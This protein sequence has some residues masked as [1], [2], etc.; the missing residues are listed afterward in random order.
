MGK[1]G[2]DAS[3]FI[4]STLTVKDH[5]AL[6]EALFQYERGYG[7]DLFSCHILVENFLQVRMDAGFHYYCFP[8]AWVKR[9]IEGDYFSIDPISAQS[10]V[11][12]E[13]FDWYD[14]G[15]L[16]KLTPAQEAYL[17]DM[18]D[19]GLVDGLAVP[20]VAAHGTIAYF[21]VG[22]SLEPMPRTDTETLEI[23]YACNHIHNL[24]SE[25]RAALTTKPQPLSPRERE[26][27]SWMAK[28]KSNAVI[29]TTLGISENAVDTLVRRCFQKLDVGDRISAAIKGLG[30]GLVTL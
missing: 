12:S 7:A 10:M 22:S 9:Y 3:S 5:R 15:R 6:F 21:G 17:Q 11:E 20:I 2:R 19:N 24:S 28:V 14:V 25:L 26:V 16:T 29:S 18:R 30:L 1:I 27:L 13:P 4:E 8:L 23:Q